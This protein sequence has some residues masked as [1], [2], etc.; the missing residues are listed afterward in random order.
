M[1][2][3]VVLEVGATLA[4]LTAV[5]TVET[6]RVVVVGGIRGSV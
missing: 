3:H 4:V 2:L 1:S 6:E 5:G